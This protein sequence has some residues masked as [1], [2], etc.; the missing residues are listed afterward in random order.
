MLAFSST[1]T[2]R[3]LGLIGVR[4][5][6]NHRQFH[7]RGKMNLIRFRDLLASRFTLGELNSL[8]FDL[9]IPFEELPGATLRE[10]AE[11]LIDYCRRRNQFPRL[12]ERCR[13][14][15]PDDDWPELTSLLEESRDA[16][17]FQHPTTSQ[18]QQGNSYSA[19]VG[20]VGAGAQIAVGQNINQVQTGRVEDIT[21]LLAELRAAVREE[22]DSNVATAAEAEI[23]VLQQE[24]QAA[25]PS[26][27]RLGQLREYF[28]GLGG[29]VA[30]AAVTL[31]KSEP[32]QAALKT[33]AEVAVAATLKNFGG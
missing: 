9:A 12:W 20:N 28:Q 15:R 7:Q 3:P 6:Q 18:A 1:V 17:Q 11:G 31:F 29:R 33:A 26:L 10:K 2:G 16:P 25:E 32:V 24:L 8:C 13:Q 19:H 14:L 4:F 5:A 22:L 23:D 27:T 21:K 30:E